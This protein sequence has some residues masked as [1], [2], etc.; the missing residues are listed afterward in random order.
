VPAKLARVSMVGKSLVQD[1]SDRGSNGHAIGGSNDH[2][3]GGQGRACA[4]GWSVSESWRER[5]L[6]TRPSRPVRRSLDMGARAFRL[7]R[8][9]ALLEAGCRGPARR[10]G[11]AH[12]AEC[13]GSLGAWAEDVH[14][15]A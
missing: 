14:L 7:A 4:V 12:L 3:I 8:E 13:V 2:A 10:T 9:P 1:G 11:W 5:R 6:H 15:Q